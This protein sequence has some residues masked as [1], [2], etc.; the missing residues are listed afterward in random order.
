MTD[1]ERIAAGIK[2]TVISGAQLPIVDFPSAL[3]QLTVD[4]ISR[5]K[6]DSIQNRT[7]C[8]L[9]SDLINF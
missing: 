6:H 8:F 9:I 4:N 7:F 2:Y 5:D 3:V 1:G